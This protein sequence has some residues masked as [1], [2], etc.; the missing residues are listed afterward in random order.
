[1]PD[2]VDIP[3]TDN[4]TMKHLFVFVVHWRIR[5]CEKVNI[6]YKMRFG[7]LSQNYPE[8]FYVPM[9]AAFMPANE[10]GVVIMGIIS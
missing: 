7:S 6:E 1:M 10:H 9:P 2:T 8:L 5:R 3:Y 4:F